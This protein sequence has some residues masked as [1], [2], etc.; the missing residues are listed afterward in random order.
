MDSCGLLD[1]V[2]FAQFDLGLTAV[3]DVAAADAPH[4]RIERV[5]AGLFD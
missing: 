5:S 1:E 2:G 4:G 3:E